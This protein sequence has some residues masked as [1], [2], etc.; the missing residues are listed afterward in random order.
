MENM[1][2]GAVPETLTKLNNGLGKAL[3]YDNIAIVVLILAVGFS[4]AFNIIQ[5]L[6]AIKKDKDQ[7]AKDLKI[8]E[9]RRKDMDKL[10]SLT[11]DRVKVDNQVVNLLE[12]INE[13]V[14]H[15]KKS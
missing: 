7:A 12:L 2:A 14:S 8:E 4:G 10:L 9:N 15:V 6:A 5:F 3:A 11:F 1:I 13:K